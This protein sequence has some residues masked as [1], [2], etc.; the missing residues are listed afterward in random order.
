M[1]V[2]QTIILLF[3]K[4]WPPFISTKLYLCTGSPSATFTNTDIKLILTSMTSIEAW[5]HRQSVGIC[6][7]GSSARCSPAS[8]WYPD[9]SDPIHNNI[10]MNFNIVT[11]RRRTHWVRLSSIG[12]CLPCSHPKTPHFRLAVK[13]RKEDALWCIPFQRPFSCC[14]SLRIEDQMS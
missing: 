5:P 11:Q 14:F 12:Q 9:P 1:S 3:P 4:A 8:A 6:L 7:D 13:L 2:S 10:M